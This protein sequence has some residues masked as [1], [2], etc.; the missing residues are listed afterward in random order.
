MMADISGHNQSE[1]PR[2]M[3]PIIQEIE[4]LFGINF[5]TKLAFVFNNIDVIYE[6]DES[7]YR[8]YSK[9]QLGAIEG[10]FN[11]LWCLQSSLIMSIINY[12][13]QF[14]VTQ[15]LSYSDDMVQDI[16]IL[17]IVD[18][19][20]QST[21]NTDRVLLEIKDEFFK[22][23]FMVK[24]S[25]TC[26]SDKRITLL[27][28]T[29]V[30]GYE[31]PNELKRMLAFSTFSSDLI[32]ND[33][34]EIDSA[35][36]SF[37][38][39]IENSINNYE[40][41]VY[42]WMRI[43]PYIIERFASFVY[44]YK[45]KVIPF[46]LLKTIEGI[47][48]NIKT[49]N[50]EETRNIRQITI[51]LIKQEIVTNNDF[52]KL[53]YTYSVLPTSVQGV[54]V[55]P[56]LFAAVSGYS[57]SFIKR[58]DYAIS[59]LLRTKCTYLKFVNDFVYSSIEFGSME[60]FV[61]S[62]FPIKSM[63][64]HPTIF[65]KKHLSKALNESIDKIKN[66]ELR[67]AIQLRESSK[68]QTS[69]VY[70]AILETFAESYSF[71]IGRKFADSM[72]KEYVDYI[73][74]KFQSSSTILKFIKNRNRF[75]SQYA[76][77]GN[78]IK[79]I[80]LRETKTVLTQNELVELRN[81]YAK[82][83]FNITYCAVEEVSLVDICRRFP[84]GPIQVV[85]LHDK[86]KTKFEGITHFRAYRMNKGIKPK[87]RNNG[88][89]WY[90]TSW[91][92]YKMFDL[93]RF[94]TWLIEDQ[95][96]NAEKD[97]TKE[98]FKLANI[99]LSE[100]ST[101]RMEDL[102]PHIALPAGGQ[103]FHRVDNSGFKSSSNI[104]KKLQDASNIHPLG[105][106]RLLMNRASAEHNVNVELFSAFLIFKKLILEEMGFRNNIE[107]ILD[108]QKSKLIMDA[109]VSLKIQLTSCE[110]NDIG[111][112]TDVEVSF[113]D[114][115][116][117]F[118]LASKLLRNCPAIDDI[119]V[120]LSDG[121]DLMS[122]DFMTLCSSI[123]QYMKEMSI[124]SL[125]DVD[126]D[127][128]DKFIHSYGFKMSIREF[129][130]KYEA[131][132]FFNE[133]FLDSDR[134]S[135]IRKVLSLKYIEK[136]DESFDSK[137]LAMKIFLI[138]TSLSF[139]SENVNP[140]S[141]EITIIT[142]VDLT[143]S[144][145]AK[146]FI[147]YSE[148]LKLGQI[149]QEIVRRVISRIDLGYLQKL[150]VQKLIKELC[151]ETTGTYN[152]PHYTM[153]KLDPLY[154]SLL[155]EMSI[156]NNEI[157]INYSHL[158]LRND[159]KHN[160]YN[161]R[162]FIDK[163]ESLCSM[164]CAI[165]GYESSVGSNM[166]H[167]AIGL[168]KN[169]L[170]SKVADVTPGRG[171][172]HNAMENLQI[173][174]VS[175]KRVDAYNK[176]IS[177]PGMI[178]KDSFNAFDINQLREYFDMDLFLYDISHSKDDDEVE[179]CL[180]ELLD[181][182]KEVL[183]RLNQFPLEK[184]DFKREEWSTIDK[185]IYYPSGVVYNCGYVYLHLK[186]STGG[187]PSI[188]ATIYEMQNS[189]AVI[190]SKIMI[191]KEA[192]QSADLIPICDKSHEEMSDQFINE[193]ITATDS[194]ELELGAVVSD[195]LVSL[196]NSFEDF[197][198]MNSIVAA[199]YKTVMDNFELRL[200]GPRV[201]MG[202]IPNRSDIIVVKESMKTRD[203]IKLQAKALRDNVRVYTDYMGCKAYTFI[204][205]VEF[206]D[207]VGFLN[208]WNWLSE[209]KVPT[210]KMKNW[211][212]LLE[213]IEHENFDFNKLKLSSAYKLITDKIK[214]KTFSTGLTSK[215]ELMSQVKFVAKCKVDGI[216]DPSSEYLLKTRPTIGSFDRLLKNERKL[217]IRL[218][219]IE[220]RINLENFT[221]EEKLEISRFELPVNVNRD[222]LK[223]AKKII[224]FDSQDIINSYVT[225]PESMTSQEMINAL[226]EA[227][228]WIG[229]LMNT[230]MTMLGHSGEV[231]R[232]ENVE[233]DVET[234]AP[235]SLVENLQN[236]T[237]EGDN[238]EFEDD[239][240]EDQGDY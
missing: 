22:F 209:L 164:R 13:K 214:M 7:D 192:I 68:V 101:L 62:S 43:V 41:L 86:I 234:E 205:D 116:Q 203:V 158:R 189:I 236:I 16:K 71:R 65:V 215:K 149:S 152:M 50:T 97:Y 174:H 32:Y 1:R 19:Q 11:P 229:K 120:I 78:Y 167:T 204:Q 70:C 53:F 72:Y 226:K 48:E 26:I 89:D 228:P 74:S 157:T 112:Y 29:Y 169:F 173:R 113:K 121:K 47:N 177:H 178:A 156:Y 93:A 218:R 35:N 2:N 84:S 107:L 175:V 225:L 75:L 129:K 141:D 206:E 63:R 208:F 130:S 104:R 127:I 190:C 103:I 111:N 126:N 179:V 28:K 82:E 137:R 92:H 201:L 109:R 17:P 145:Y 165:A 110:L 181:S 163:F 108:A 30:N 122:Q 221:R 98:L 83:Q 139:T 231:E 193:A 55:I 123:S 220:K 138:N 162:Q 46:D 76:K 128:L 197:I 99:I 9:H 239:Y 187:D 200:A 52:A 202:E 170:R 81:N 142:D 79:M 5:L 49:K 54:G 168:M 134:N 222:N 38:S 34:V 124:A 66:K 77:V 186:K 176:I 212:Y 191:A 135:H 117:I 15:E 150:N 217:I 88:I 224:E 140:G 146:L 171:D 147:D 185:T 160:F 216:A 227:N 132:Y 96:V 56:Y 237:L 155:N 194:G 24:F 100:Y 45:D 102:S 144:N 14:K 40:L 21:I 161:F 233:A 180:L 73:V 114:N 95:K 136:I 238:E 37:S 153:M 143:I 33:L 36:S 44:M 223:K 182:N 151:N 91:M 232:T 131:Q 59:G 58:V 118:H 198:T 12:D 3:I 87:Y 188:G 23:G 219:Q 31:M 148:T 172:F 42:R 27:K 85:K 211:A 64:D 154:D 213:I 115:I 133:G 51:N 184:I 105:I 235:V 69:I 18:E 6:T 207:R 61:D 196:G 119:P 106:N 25:Q 60:K 90:F 240:F 230:M 183:L 166:Y 4:Q 199:D 57:D 210:L 10:W 8:Y 39:M 20:G 67:K 125:N 80:E 195:M 94:V 159:R